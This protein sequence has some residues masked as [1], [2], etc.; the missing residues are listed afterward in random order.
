MLTRGTPHAPRAGGFT[1][2][3]VLIAIA[4]LAFGLLGLAGLQSKMQLAEMEAYQRTQAILLVTDMVERL[5]ANRPDAASYATATALGT[6]DAQPA[7]CTAIAFGVDR[8]KC[9]WSNALKGA[10]EQSDDTNVG[11][12]LNARGCVTEIQAL[13]ATPG[14][15]A[16]GIYQVTVTW[17]GLNETAAPAFTCP[18]DVAENTL[19]SVTSYVAVGTPGCA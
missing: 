11:A 17:Q 13:N 18:G 1:L 3:E 5:S 16:A 19:R 4:I 8:D 7:S 14:A 9:E 15:C 6:G 10:A 2:I 12:M